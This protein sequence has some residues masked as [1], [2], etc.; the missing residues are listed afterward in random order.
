MKVLDPAQLVSHSTV[1]FVPCLN[2]SVLMEHLYTLYTNH[3]EMDG[4]SATYGV[5]L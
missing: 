4:I 5:C 3:Q 2:S 1:S